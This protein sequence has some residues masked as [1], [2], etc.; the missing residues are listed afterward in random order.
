MSL[1]CCDFSTVVL[2]SVIDAV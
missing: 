2:K 1:A